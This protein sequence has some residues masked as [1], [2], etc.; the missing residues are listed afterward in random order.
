[1][2]LI[3]LLLYPAWPFIWLHKAQLD[4]Y[5]GRPLLF[6]PLGFLALLLLP[7][8]YGSRDARYLLLVC[9]VPLRDVYDPILLLLVARQPWEWLLLVG[10]PWVVVLI[11]HNISPVP[12]AYTG[13]LVWFLM[14]LPAIAIVILRIIRT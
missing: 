5:V 12:L 8:A 2:G 3:S 14:G 4:V 1:M 7:F 13:T 10:M 11:D 9:L 6:E